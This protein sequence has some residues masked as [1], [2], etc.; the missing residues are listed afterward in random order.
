MNYISMINRSLVT[1]STKNDV[2]KFF[3]V[4][5]KEIFLNL[6]TVERF[7]EQIDCKIS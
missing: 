7:G 3:G 6:V 4:T 5:I 2:L 1:R